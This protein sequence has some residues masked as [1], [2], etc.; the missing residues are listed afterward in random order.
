MKMFGYTNGQLGRWLAQISGKLD[1]V[2]RGWAI[3]LGGNLGRMAL[4]FVASVLVAR[5][6]GPAAFGVYAVLGAAMAITGVMADMGL[7]VTEVKRVASVWPYEPDT[8]HLRG[9]V[10]SWLRAGAALLFF[11]LATFLAVPIANRIL[12]LS[13]IPNGPLL[14]ILAMAGM[15]AVTLSGTVS[16]L[17]QATNHFGRL[18]TMSLVNAGLTAILALVLFVIG[19]LNLVTALLILG[20]GT[21]LASFFVGY[22]L[23]PGRWSLWQLPAVQDLRLEGAALFH[24]S[25]WLWVASLFTVVIMQI[26][27]IM[28]GRLTTAAAAGLY[29]LAI[30][31]ARKADIVNQSLYTS[32]LPAAS[33]LRDREAV[34]KYLRQSLI[35]SGLIALGLLVLMPLV[36]PFIRIF[37]GPEYA[38]A[39]GLLQLL[40]VVVI[41]D[42]FA[43]PVTLL[44]F[45]L[46]RP[47]LYAASTALQAII[48]LLLAAWLIPLIGTP[49]AAVAK[50]VARS[51]GFVLVLWRL[52]LWRL[53]GRMNPS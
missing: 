8:A 30:N 45:P 12:G 33:S 20:I 40:L 44:V 29:G 17:L 24:F 22:R 28:V 19:R 21:T 32:L 53:P 39:T 25:R 14:F 9:R 43:T 18:S 36:G 1:P 49:G 47:K 34:S 23:L 41:I 15:L 35:R 37:Y 2:S 52:R 3:V 26:D 48:L 6:L 42:A 51:T 5:A 50:I 46:E 13:D 10:A 31:L 16:T 11:F 4:S 27:V 38:A 7:T